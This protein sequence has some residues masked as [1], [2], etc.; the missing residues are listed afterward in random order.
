MSL[1]LL[2]LRGTPPPFDQVLPRPADP[3]ADVYDVV[4]DVVRRAR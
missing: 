1:R 3:G 2:N 4:A